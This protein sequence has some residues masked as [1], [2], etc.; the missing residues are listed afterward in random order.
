MAKETEPYRF[1]PVRE[2][3]HKKLKVRCAQEEKT[4]DQLLQELV[5]KN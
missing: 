2:S 1:I 4:F 3:T 5:E